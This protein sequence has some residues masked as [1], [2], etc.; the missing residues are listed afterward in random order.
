MTQVAI[1]VGKRFISSRP[2]DHHL[3]LERQADE[4]C[5]HPVEM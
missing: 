5:E 1:P 2:S 3:L 4:G